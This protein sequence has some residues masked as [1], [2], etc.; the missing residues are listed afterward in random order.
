MANY[1]LSSTSTIG[2]RM[3]NRMHQVYIPLTTEEEQ[4][5]QAILFRYYC[6]ATA[7]KSTVI[8]DHRL[9]PQHNAFFST[10]PSRTVTSHC[11]E[12]RGLAIANPLW[13]GAGE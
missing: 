11:I 1:Y 13:Y 8:S 12:T 5:L 2:K 10:R 6:C 3:T 9:Q 4:A 7:C